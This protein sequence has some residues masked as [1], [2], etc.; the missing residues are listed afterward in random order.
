MT[1]ATVVYRPPH[2]DEE[3]WAS[4]A[5]PYD[6]SGA[7][8]HCNR[9]CPHCRYPIDGGREHIEQPQPPRSRHVVC[10]SRWVVRPLGEALT[11][12][13]GHQRDHVRPRA[14]AEPGR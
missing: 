13:A 3:W 9:H 2:P 8:V 10:E 6:P 14:V 5:K 4:R 12:F 7:C 1:E 11:L